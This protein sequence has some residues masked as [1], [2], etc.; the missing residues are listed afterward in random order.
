[1]QVRAHSLR[2]HYGRMGNEKTCA[3]AEGCWGRRGHIR[4]GADKKK[5]SHPR[6]PPKHLTIH[7]HSRQ[8]FLLRGLRCRGGSRSPVAPSH[9]FGY[10]HPRRAG[11]GGGALSSP[12]S[13]LV[14]TAA[15]IRATPA[16][17]DVDNRDRSPLGL[18]VLLPAPGPSSSNTVDVLGP[19]HPHHRHIHR[20]SATAES[21]RQRNELK[22]TV[23]TLDHS[24]TTPDPGSSS[25]GFIL[26][27]VHPDPG[28]RV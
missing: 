7:P 23:R 18:P 3:W 20:T 11:S 5:D 24:T 21:K 26:V 14:D 22:R 2:R 28:L 6:S 13:S 10:L 8:W 25:S 15:H 4:S 19:P 12:A 1:M 9:K 27:L 16:R 17:K